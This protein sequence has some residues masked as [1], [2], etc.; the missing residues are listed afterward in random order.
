MSAAEPDYVPARQCGRGITDPL[1][2][3]GFWTAPM[4]KLDDRGS[5]ILAILTQHYPGRPLTSVHA[6]REI[7]D[8]IGPASVDGAQ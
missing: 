5:R 4:R 1:F 6:T 3:V 8:A 2:D 7:V